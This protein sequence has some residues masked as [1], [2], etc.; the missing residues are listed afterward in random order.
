MCSPRLIPGYWKD[1]ENTKNSFIK[2]G[3]KT[4][5]RTGDVGEIQTQVRGILHVT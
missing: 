3:E 1:E 2:I 5:Y 4:Y